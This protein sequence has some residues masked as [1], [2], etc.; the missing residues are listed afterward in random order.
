MIVTHDQQASALP[1]RFHTRY[2]IAAALIIWW[3][4]VW[5]TIIGSVSQLIIT[6]NST[7]Q[8]HGLSLPLTANEIMSNFGRLYVHVYDLIKINR[9]LWLPSFDYLTGWYLV[10]DIFRGQIKQVITKDIGKGSDPH[11]VSFILKSLGKADFP[12]TTKKS[13]I[14]LYLRWTDYKRIDFSW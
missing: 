2:W 12:Y 8:L 6:I 7:N 1:H 3:E 9:S 11:R 13:W 5:W 14:L 10:S 4:L